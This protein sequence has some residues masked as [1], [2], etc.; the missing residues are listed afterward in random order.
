MGR[1][2]AFILLVAAIACAAAGA[3]PAIQNNGELR[4][5]VIL[6]TW[7]PQPFTRA[8]AQDVV[9]TQS[10]A[11]VTDNSFGAAHLTGEVT[12]WVKAFPSA[13]ACGTPTEQKSLATAAQAAAKTAGFDTASYTRFIYLFPP[14]SSCGYGG[15]GSLTE[16]FL[17]GQLGRGLVTHEL[18][19][20]FGLEHAH[21]HLCGAGGCET[22]EYGDPYDTM[23]STLVGEYNAY[24]K[25]VAGWLT[26]V[27]QAPK[28]G[29]YVI[30]QLEV[31]STVPQALA[32]QTA[33]NEYWFDHR[34]PL[35]RDAVFAGKPVVQG[36]AVHAGPP[37][38]DP[39][40]QS[41]FSTANTLLPNPGGH[42]HPILLPGDAFSEPGAFR[43]TV[44]GHTGTQVA[45][46]FE[47]T[48]KTSP[49]KPALSKPPAHP[50]RNRSFLARWEP[51]TDGGS[52]LHHYVVSLDGRGVKTVTAD[53][54]LP[55]QAGV[56]PTSRGKHTL[57]VVAYDRAG[58]ASRAAVATFTV[59]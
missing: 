55:T 9:F 43:L 1:G 42:G 10:N 36:L 49:S 17:N 16:V 3:A 58:N 40:A 53:F 7:G 47:W 6:A 54:K 8:Q 29:D 22:I 38:S 48:D 18:G 41:D 51:S 28:S 19:H 56:R 26:N 32:V 4:V 46:H 5:L 31:K 35:L 2:V 52:G 13:P 44:T 20:T 15:Y 34:E 25:F 45:V 11:F 12:P 39:T 57:R 21:L 24:E 59:R 30:D 27:T 50:K 14:I 23:G 37:S 33:S